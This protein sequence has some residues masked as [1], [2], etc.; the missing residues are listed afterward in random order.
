MCIPY[1]DSP[2]VFARILDE[3]KGGHFSI[4]PWVQRVSWLTGSTF[5]Y[6]TKQQYMPNS[7]VLSTK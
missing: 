1:F 4:T 5:D 3:N 6:T 7:N 2:S